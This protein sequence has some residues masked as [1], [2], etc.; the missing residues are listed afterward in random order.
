MA[1]PKRVPLDVFL[2]GR[3]VG[4]L[5]R[6]ASG[7]ISFRYD[8]RWLTWEHTFPISLSLPLREDRYSGD[9][10][11]AVFDNLLPDNKEARE[12]LAARK[13]AGGT[14]AYH[15]LMQ[16]GRDCVGALQFLP[17]GEEP[18]TP[19][20]IDARALDE[21]GVEA[22]LGELGLSPLGLGDDEDFRISL[23]GAQDK[24]AL[25]YHEGQW[26]VP[27]GTTPT[28]HIFKPPIGVR[29]EFDL[30]PSVENEHFCMTLL[31]KL[32]LPVAPTRIETFGE[33]IALVVERFDRRWTGDGR[34]LRLP[35][36][37]CCQALSVPPGTKYESD[38]GPGIPAVI[39]LF[40]GSNDP[41]RDQALLMKAMIIYW[42]MAA[43]DGHAK[44]FSLFLQPQGRFDLTPFYDV[45]SVQPLIDAGQLSA[46]KA[47]MAMAVG[48]NRHYKLHEIVPRHFIFTAKRAGMGESTVNEI[49]AALVET[50]EPALDAARAAMPE[51]FPH[52]ICDSII[53]G[54]RARLRTLAAAITAEAG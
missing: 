44:N 7:A 33:R 34:L 22:L 4:T 13:K 17:A 25:L 28:T 11:I 32:G 24:T 3:A 30:T 42:L 8:E 6:E 31:G 49:F 36:E 37:D 52:H 15:L 39:D 19:G 1:R 16:V 54:Y 18:S 40:R 9:P 14:D 12:K 26:H 53:S 45:M 10:V 46:R 47:K 51:G 50:S 20:T 38:G 29:G 41:A 5:S 43:T 35:Q 27:H 48:K 21:Q 2:N 23:A